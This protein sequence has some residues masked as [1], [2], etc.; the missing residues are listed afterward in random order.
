M[1]GSMVVNSLAAVLIVTSLLVTAA[2][3]TAR[4]A[5]LYAVQSLVLV[6]IFVALA[7]AHGAE[8][9]YL[10]AASAFVTKVILVPMIMLRA[11]PSL[12]PQDDLPGVL[13]PAWLVLAAALIVGLSCYAVS[14]VHI[15]LVEPLKPA[16]GIS[17]GHFLFGL[18]C[19]VTQ[20]SILKQIFGFCLMENGSHLTLALLA[21]KAPEIV[22]I[23]VATDAVFAVII[24]VVL[25][26][27][28]QRT[29]QS[30]DVKQ[31]T[32]LKG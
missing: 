10:W 18:V 19:I 2:S 1:D 13:K 8:E 26:R 11:L 24:M 25:V 27:R 31:L 20:R 5:R 3:D 6:A 23:G 17:L 32:A 16:L 9:L 30:L 7:V 22:E 14:S 21:Y 29:L 15:A 28:I 4:A 12:S